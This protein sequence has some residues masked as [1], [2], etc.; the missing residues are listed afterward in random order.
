MS[1][2]IL[3]AADHPLPQFASGERRIRSVSTPDGTL[4]VEEDGFS[5]APLTYYKS[6]VENLA[7]AMKP[8]LYELDL[9]DTPQDLLC[10]RSYLSTYGSPGEQIELWNLWV[11]GEDDPVR[12]F[13]GAFRDFDLETLKQLLETWQTC[14][15]IT[16]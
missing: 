14:V 1:Q 5:V 16:I 11:G 10:L 9:R 2:V 8:Y 12:H 3:L 15:T 6:A 4:R 7:L 13:S